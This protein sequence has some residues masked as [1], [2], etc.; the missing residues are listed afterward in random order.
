[1]IPAS[2]RSAIAIAVCLAACHPRA[3]SE[4][5]LAPRS[6][7]P[8]IA[9][10]TTPCFGTCPEYLLQIYGDG[11]VRYVGM[12][13]TATVGVRQDWL[14][15][16][17]LQTLVRSFEDARFDALE[18]AYEAAVSDLPRTVLT[19]RHGGRTKTV[20]RMHLEGIAPPELLALERSI[21]DAV[22]IERWIGREQRASQD[23]DVRGWR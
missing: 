12:R 4:T 15:R 16:S 21:E 17:A 1:M 2:A 9:L 6:D 19:F 20:S 22:H 7:D 18:D 11:E 13:N 3:A 14:D 23:S 10:E 5:V 8:V